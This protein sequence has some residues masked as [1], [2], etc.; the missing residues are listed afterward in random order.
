[1]A[2]A[3]VD[4]AHIRTLLLTFFFR[5]MRPMIENGYVYPPCPPVQ[6]DPG[7][8]HQGCLPD[9]QR[10]TVSAQMRSD[11]PNAKVDIAR[12]KGLGEMDP[13][14]S[15][16][17]HH[18]SGAAPFAGSLLDDA[19]RADEIFTVLMGEQVEPRKDW[20][21]RNAKYAVNLDFKTKPSPRGV[22]RRRRDGWGRTKPTAMGD[23]SVSLGL[24]AP[25]AQGG[26]LSLPP[27]GGTFP[28][29]GK[30]FYIGGAFMAQQKLQT[31]GHCLPL[32]R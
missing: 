5:Y 9:E 10:D 7:Q 15:V 21:E 8:D 13:T 31:R 17:D 30:V 14:A 25:F 29:E 11:N 22:A 12:Y 6:A 28:Q 20:I 26:S 4:G 18:G 3:D 19:A 23:P 27:P 24:T 16:G 1:M 2:D 32:T